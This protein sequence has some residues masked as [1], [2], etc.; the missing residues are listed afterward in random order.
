MF[1]ED[2]QQNLDLIAKSEEN[3]KFAYVSFEDIQT[4]TS[5]NEKDQQ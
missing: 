1:T 3:N 5:F 2:I 4:L